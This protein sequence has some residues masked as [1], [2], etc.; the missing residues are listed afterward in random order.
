MLLL[1]YF[2]PLRQQ[3]LPTSNAAPILA[4]PFGQRANDA[5]EISPLLTTRM[6]PDTALLQQLQQTLVA[7]CHDAMRASGVVI[8][9]SSLGGLGLFAGERDIAPRE[10]LATYCGRL[11]HADA[12]QH[13][14][15]AALLRKL[16]YLMSFP[17]S[18]TAD[19]NTAWVL[20]A[21]VDDDGSSDAID[22]TFREC[23]ALRVNEP[24]LDAHPNAAIAYNSARRTVEVWSTSA[25]SAGHEVLLYYGQG[26]NRDYLISQHLYGIDAISIDV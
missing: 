3:L 7:Q 5:A 9:A 12:L 23:G 10:H 16:E 14:P 4:V 24:P 6:D 17:Y 20:D 22:V 8:R 2:P 11:R 26:Y 13:L 19:H 25:I 1:L 18:P 21:T 15:P